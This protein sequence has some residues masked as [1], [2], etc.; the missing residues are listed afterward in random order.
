MSQ[1]PLVPRSRSLKR[2]FSFVHDPIPVF[3]EYL[4][5]YGDTYS[6][7]LGG[8]K[9]VIV[10]ADPIIMRH[11]L[12]KNHKNYEKSEIQTDLLAQYIGYGLLT[13]SGK[14]WFKQRRLIQ[15][16]F[17]KE[18]IKSL[19]TLI[20]E[21][22]DKQLADLESKRGEVIDFYPVTMDIAFKI[23]GNAMFSESASNDELDKIEDIILKLQQFVVKRARQPF[24]YPIYWLNGKL[25]EHKKLAL[26][27]ENIVLKIIRDR[28]KLDTQ[29][30]DLLGMLINTRYEDTGEPMVEEQM[31][32][33]TNILFVAGHETTANALSWMLY[34]LAK[35]PEV[36][37]ELKEEIKT[38]LEDGAL[39]FDILMKMPLLNAV[40]MET[41]RIYPPAWIMDRVA[42]EDDEAGGFKIS[43]GM[44][45]LPLVYHAHFREQD[46]V[47]PQ[48]FNPQR[49]VDKKAHSAYFPF[50]AGPRMC[51]GNNFAMLEMQ[52]FLVQFLRRYNVALSDETKVKIKPLIT[53][54]PAFGMK[55][56]L[57]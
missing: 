23:M 43:K 10:T 34:L 3:Y 13:N 35:H 37:A 57:I 6:I 29:P 56:K 12:Q 1:I 9:K 40:I 38:S 45:I 19:V 36:V 24:M 22:V 41:L 51:I 49:F 28:K 25:K 30:D 7:Y 15:P 44:M 8:I 39:D 27:I 5:D 2:T 52:V 46:W 55:L 20:Q 4:Q 42:L 48:Q 54:K 53:L 50:G 47:N 33:E 18:R 31:L 21:G 14:N 11:V 16:G 26:D 32:W 17:H